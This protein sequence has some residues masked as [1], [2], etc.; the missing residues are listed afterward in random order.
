MGTNNDGQKN[1]LSIVFCIGVS[2]LIAA[3]SW[4]EWN[5]N[6]NFIQGSIPTTGHIEL[7]RLE[8][9]TGYRVS[10]QDNFFIIYDYSI[11]SKG[12]RATSMI[13]KAFYLSPQSN[14]PVN[15]LYNRR[16]QMMRVRWCNCKILNR[17]ATCLLLRLSSIFLV[18]DF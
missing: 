4:A 10:S 5:K 1:I 17:F 12:Y 7:K 15:L 2:A 3:M 11:D 16:N 9:K 6:Q 18:S 14:K 13:P 8:P